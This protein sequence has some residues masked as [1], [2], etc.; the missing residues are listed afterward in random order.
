MN[1]VD[2]F[3]SSGYLHHLNTLVLFGER[4]FNQAVVQLMV[5]QYNFLE[6]C[7]TIKHFLLLQRGDF[8]Q[9]LISEL[10]VELDAPASS[11][12]R[13]RLASLLENAL[14]S[15]GTQ[16]LEELSPYLGVEIAQSGIGWEAFT[17]T[18]KVGVPL[19][20]VLTKEVFD[21]YAHVFHFLLQLKRVENSVTTTRRNCSLKNLRHVHLNKFHI[22]HNLSLRFIQDIQFFFMNTVIDSAWMRLVENLKRAS[23]LDQIIAVHCEYLREISEHVLLRDKE[24]QSVLNKILDSTLAFQ[25]LER[26]LFMNIQVFTERSRSQLE[27]S[28]ETCQVQ[29]YEE[30]NKLGKLSLEFDQLFET[31][32]GLFTKYKELRSLCKVPYPKLNK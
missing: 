17:L 25:S 15:L 3:T 13:H 4:C 19:N 11:I 10:E 12:Y 32:F 2:S 5:N 1:Q 7:K 26:A 30:F 29:D 9:A 6:H 21:R 8:T 24:I 20:T 22:L 23:N 31:I 27:P 28:L 14:S 18:Y 16:V